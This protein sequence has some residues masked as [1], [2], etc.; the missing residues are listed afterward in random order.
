M[1]YNFTSVSNVPEGTDNGN[2]T[3]DIRKK[4]QIGYYVKFIP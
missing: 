2:L 3:K 1:T 4:A